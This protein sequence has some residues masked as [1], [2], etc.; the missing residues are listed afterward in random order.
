MEQVED[1]MVDALVS[2]IQRNMAEVGTHIPRSQIRAW[3]MG[4][5]P[6]Y[7]STAKALESLGYDSGGSTYAENKAMWERLGVS[8]YVYDF[9]CAASA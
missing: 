4:G 1:V 9:I 8:E 7:D 6:F 3:L 2:T 5:G